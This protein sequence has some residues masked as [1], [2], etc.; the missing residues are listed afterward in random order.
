MRSIHLLIDQRVG[1]YVLRRLLHRKGVGAIFLAESVE[2][3]G[4]VVF[5]T[6]NDELAGKPEAVE[7]FLDAARQAARLRHP[8]IVRINGVDSTDDGRP[9][10]VMERV[11][12]HPLGQVIPAGEGIHPRDAL[13]LL[14][15]ICKGLEAGHQQGVPHLRLEPESILIVD[16]DPPQVKLLNFGMA[17]CSFIPERPQGARTSARVNSGGGRRPWRRPGR[18][19]SFLAPEVVD[20]DPSVAG[21][22]SDVFGLG[23]VLYWMLC[24][25]PPFGTQGCKARNI[26]TPEPLDRLRPKVPAQA[27]DLIKRCLAF[28]PEQRPG[29]PAEVF[30]VMERSV[31]FAPVRGLGDL[32]SRL[33]NLSEAG[34]SDEPNDQPTGGAPAARHRSPTGDAPEAR[35]APTGDAP[36]SRRLAPV[37]SPRGHEGPQATSM[38]LPTLDIMTG[39]RQPAAERLPP[40]IPLPPVEPSPRPISA[41]E[42]TVG[43]DVPTVRELPLLEYDEAEM[44][45]QQAEDR[46]VAKQGTDQAP[47]GTVGPDVPTV[48]ELPLLES[49]HAG[50]DALST[51][52]DPTDP[53]ST[54]EELQVLD[55]LLALESDGMSQQ[56]QDPQALDDQPTTVMPRLPSGGGGDE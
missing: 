25:S 34:G 48:R 4:E 47:T 26:Q 13:P 1:D 55:E 50:V 42:S 23:A 51:D 9:Y 32:V 8:N 40:R 7:S 16:R 17:R 28:A 2:Q 20:W 11:D 56:D 43:P 5:K 38:A 10:C 37:N 24:G 54:M 21:K 53:C 27:A 44:G 41:Q 18:G 33:L 49:D 6:L 31:T 29:S 15:Q 46:P 19:L 22:A 30:E 14:E 12:G 3:G 36:E 39:D 45:Q 35:L 52:P